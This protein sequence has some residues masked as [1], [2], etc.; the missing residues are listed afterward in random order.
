KPGNMSPF[1][2]CLRGQRRDISPYFLSVD[3]DRA[4]VVMPDALLAVAISVRCGSP[5]PNAPQTARGPPRLCRAPPGNRPGTPGS[6]TA[7]GA[8][9]R[10]APR[11]PNSSFDEGAAVRS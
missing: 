2:T 4:G 9:S 11:H 1:T 5:R 7:P 8:E 6:R 3:A 10:P